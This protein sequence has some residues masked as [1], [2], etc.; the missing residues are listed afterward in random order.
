MSSGEW[1]EGDVL[2]A[3]DGIKSDIRAQV[4]QEHGVKDRS[5]STGDA[6]CRVIIPREK[7]QGDKRALELLDTRSRWTHNGLPNQE[8]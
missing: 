3:A 4:A 7:M 1:T 5:I 6:A 8:Q 2:I